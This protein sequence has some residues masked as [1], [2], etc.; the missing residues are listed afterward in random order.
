MTIGRM[1]DRARGALVGLGGWR[2]V[3]AE[4]FRLSVDSGGALAAALAPRTGDVARRPAQIGDHLAGAAAGHT[5]PRPVGLLGSIS[6][7]ALLGRH[8]AMTLAFRG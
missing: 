6:A 1:H 2:S 8:E 5:L 3:V 7:V 4:P